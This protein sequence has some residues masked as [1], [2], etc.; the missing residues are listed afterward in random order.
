MKSIWFVIDDNNNYYKIELSKTLLHFVEFDFTYFWE[1]CIEAGKAARKTGYLPQNQLAVAKNAIIKCHPYVD[2]CISINFDS[3][4]LDCI[5]EYICRSENVGLEELW[6]RCISP[7]SQYEKAIFK[8][9]SEYKTNRAINQWVNIVRLQE[10]AKNKIKFI[11]YNENDEPVTDNVLR[12]RK[13]YFDL[14][15]SVAANELG[16]PTSELPYVRMY[17]PA[18]MPNASFMVSKVSKAIYKRIS[19]TIGNAEQVYY[20]HVN[21]V[22]RDQLALDAYGYVKNL[23]RP[24]EIDMNFAV[25]AVSE[26]PAVVYMPNSF[27]A[28]IDL[29]FDMM[30][31]EK[32]YLCKCAS[33]G[34]YFT[35]NDDYDKPY[36][37]RVNST[38]KTC[39]DIYEK[40]LE[41]KRGMEAAARAAEKAAEEAELG[42]AD[43][44]GVI[45]PE[46]EKHCQRVYNSVYKKIGKSMTEQEFKEWS[47]Y[48]SSMKR[49]I[50]INEATVEQLVDFL[51][52]SERMY[53]EVK[54][55]GRPKAK[56][57][58]TETERE[59][60]EYFN[61]LLKDE[62]AEEKPVHTLKNQPAL[63]PFIPETFDTMYDAVMSEWAKGKNV[64][65]PDTDSNEE[66]HPHKREIRLP[67]WEVIKK[68]I[69]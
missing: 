16:F 18:L 60:D 3:I 15:F 53:G 12:T 2:A 28:V 40:E 6:A 45:S 4:A 43:G 10:Y 61:S 29:E 35:V 36:C 1:Q 64:E 63:K 69:K 22:I 26:N 50:K 46:L 49:N 56:K 8:R 14:S 34:R 68:D 33:C 17:S 37:D 42:K 67:Q 23:T 25:E 39:R 58:K 20:S 51:E 30:L 62:K 47:Q 48:L 41:I 44:T 13:E 57:E 31:T 24:A 55:V 5:I 27:K 65:Q 9:I 21:D 38:G 59:A 54:P 32:E 66:V 7:K 19:E 52:Y 11:F